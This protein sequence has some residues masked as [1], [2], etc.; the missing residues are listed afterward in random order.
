MTDH[1]P[2]DQAYTD[3]YYG[4]RFRGRARRRYLATGHGSGRYY[5]LA[6]AVLLDW[7]RGA[8]VRSAAVSK[9]GVRLLTPV[10]TD[11]TPNFDPCD[12]CFPLALARVA[13]DGVVELPA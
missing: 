6:D 13:T 11:T 5:H 9:C 10:M 3:G 2:Y 7:W 1:M 8:L 12:R 4:V